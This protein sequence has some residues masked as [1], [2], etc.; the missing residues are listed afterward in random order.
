MAFSSRRENNGI[1]D[2]KRHTWQRF[3]AA[4]SFT[5]ISCFDILK[6]GKFP[7]VP[8]YSY[9]YKQFQLCGRIDETESFTQNSDWCQSK[10]LVGIRIEI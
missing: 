6:L 5:M 8:R 7:S 3:R 4:L 10:L 2:N 1:T 9:T